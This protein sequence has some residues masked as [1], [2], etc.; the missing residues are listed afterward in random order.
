MDTKFLIENT[1]WVAGLKTRL[2][3]AELFKEEINVKEVDTIGFL[4][5][6][7]VKH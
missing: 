7:I 6:V 2:L 4:T 5:S 1:V 3:T